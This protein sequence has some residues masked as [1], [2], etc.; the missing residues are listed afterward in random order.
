MDAIL[1]NLVGRSPVLGVSE[2][3][4]QQPGD[5]PLDQYLASTGAGEPQLK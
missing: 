2:D 3:G 4:R 1:K 5:L